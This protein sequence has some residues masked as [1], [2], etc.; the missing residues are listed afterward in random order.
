MVLLISAQLLVYRFLGLI[1]PARSMCILEYALS[2]KGTNI[3]GD[4]MK[5]P[6]L[7]ILNAR[8]LT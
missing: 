6:A 7:E 2:C 3:W 5:E 8:T 4:V 1:E